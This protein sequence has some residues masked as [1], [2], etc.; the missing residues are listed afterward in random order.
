MSLTAAQLLTLSEALRVRI[1]AAPSITSYVDWFV[2]SPHRFIDKADF[3]AA[4]KTVNDTQLEIET[5]LIQAL[6]IDRT[7]FEI[8]GAE[9]GTLYLN[10]IYEVTIFNEDD[11][12]RVD[13]TVPQDDFEKLVLLRA[14][15]HDAAVFSLLAE[16]SSTESVAEL[17]VD[18]AVAETGII[19]QEDET[20]RNA[21]CRFLTDAAITGSQTRLQ[22]PVKIQVPC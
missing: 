5:D 11:L 4:Y 15:E 2:P 19:G 17:L 9:P 6:W 18:F 13:E 3:W 8:E 12:T 1:M 16:F 7:R 21:N 20:E 14:H 22:I 10:V